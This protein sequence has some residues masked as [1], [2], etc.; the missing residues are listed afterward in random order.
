MHKRF[1]LLL[2]VFLGSYVPAAAQTPA[3]RIV[4]AQEHVAPIIMMPLPTVST[5]L[6]TA[7]FLLSRDPGHFNA[8][9]SLMFAGAYERDYRLEDLSPMDEV[10]TLSLTQS[11]LPLI[12]L[13]RGRL[14]LDAFQSTLHI[15]NVLVN[16]FDDGDTRGSRLPGQSYPGGPR[17]DHLSGLSRN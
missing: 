1:I 9:F 11:S 4:R 16:P 8:H 14:Q 3:P 12:Q 7:S 15:Q 10:K 13:W 6:P 2:G 5:P 17:S